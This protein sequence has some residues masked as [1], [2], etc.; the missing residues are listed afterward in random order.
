MAAFFI[1]LIVSK[2]IHDPVRCFFSERF[3][4]D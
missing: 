1:L 4:S 2:E 3:T